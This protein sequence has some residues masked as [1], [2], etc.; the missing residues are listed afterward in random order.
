M[1]IGFWDDEGDKR[2]R[3]AYFEAFKQPVWTQG[4]WIEVHSLTGGV[5]VFGR[6]DG[7]L[8]PAGVRF[9]SAEIYSV[10]EELRDI[11]DDCIAVGQKLGDGDE[12]VY[13]ERI[14]SCSSTFLIALVPS[15]LFVKPRQGDLTPAIVDTIKAA[16]RSNL[17]TRHVPAKIIYCP[18]I[19]YTTNFKRLEVSTL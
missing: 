5:T 13:V 8:N 12:R 16:I 18:K 11:V 19:P 14:I 1:P 10:V 4:D 9:G 15:V 7:V 17:S 3:S 2:Y 6:S